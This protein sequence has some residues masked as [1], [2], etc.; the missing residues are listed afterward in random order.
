MDLSILV[1]RIAAISYLAISVALLIG[2]LKGAQ[3]IESFEKSRGLTL[4]TGF[5]SL[6]LGAILI[7]YHNV[8]VANWRVL[9]TIIAWASFV[10]GVL[11]I[12][13]P[14]A[15]FKLTKRMMINE[16]IWGLFALAL[17]LLFAYFGFVA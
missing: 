15:M 14:A 2:E 7:Q 3:L 1:A 6:I 10:K 8:W 13:F 5:L 11:Y 16:N 17:G 12:A 9:V 4:I